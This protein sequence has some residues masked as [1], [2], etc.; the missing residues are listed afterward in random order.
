MAT[1]EGHT[2]DFHLLLT[3]MEN[4]PPRFDHEPEYSLYYRSPIILNPNVEWEAANIDAY[5]PTPQKQTVVAKGMSPYKHHWFRYIGSV[6][7]RTINADDYYSYRKWFYIPHDQ[8]SVTHS[9]M[10]KFNE[11]QKR[12]DTYGEFTY[13]YYPEKLKLLGSDGDHFCIRMN[14]MM[15]QTGEAIRIKYLLHRVFSFS[16]TPSILRH[17]I[18]ITY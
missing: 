5:I 4:E 13:P 17:G 6:E 8:E 15:L 10:K 9:F 1:S 2:S 14:R 7:R 12:Q 16:G 11:V 3:N 18:E